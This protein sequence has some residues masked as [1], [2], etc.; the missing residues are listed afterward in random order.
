MYDCSLT[1][2]QCV[3]SELVGTY[4]YIDFT[5]TSIRSFGSYLTF[6]PY[7]FMLKGLGGG[8]N[9]GDSIGLGFCYG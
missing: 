3:L 1:H 5:F 8:G 2:L 6:E 7:K 4:H 9:I